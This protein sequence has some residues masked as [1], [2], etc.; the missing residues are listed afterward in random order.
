[1]NMPNLLIV[2]GKKMGKQTIIDILAKEM[3]KDEFEM[4]YLRLYAED[5]MT[6]DEKSDNKKQSYISTSRVGSSAGSKFTFP[7][8]IQA[9]VK[10]FVEIK[11]YGTAPFKILCVKKFDILKREQPGFRRLMEMYSSNV[12][13]VLITDQVSAIIEPIVS[14]CH[15]VFIAGL[16]YDTF[17]DAV[18]NIADLESFTIDERA[19]FS[20]F[21]VSE[22]SFGKA[23]DILQICC[24]K[25]KNISEKDLFKATDMLTNSIC[26][27]LLSTVLNKGL[28]TAEKTLL[29]IF[30]GYKYTA[31]EI[32]TFMV[33]EVHKLPLERAVKA[34]LIELIA[35]SDMDASYGRNDHIQMMSLL[36]KLEYI[37]EVL[38]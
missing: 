35:D 6:D 3:L 1:M 31:K 9:R 17:V 11:K 23:L 37:S 36:A 22:G 20:L 24:L 2:G 12:R 21:K 18:M 26:G 30:R 7:A 13:F 28:D 38:K 29:E 16:D 25:N 33:K 27:T 34:K 4:N 8:F 19:M 5:P 32:M 15:L 14:R 10:P